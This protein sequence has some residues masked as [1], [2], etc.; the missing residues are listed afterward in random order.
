MNGVKIILNHFSLEALFSSYY[1]MIIY[2]SI[3]NKEKYKVQG[4]FFS[5]RFS[6]FR[7]FF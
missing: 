4:V 1:F 3:I 7:T 6:H 2:H 5:L